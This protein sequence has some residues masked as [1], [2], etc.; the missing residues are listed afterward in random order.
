M[1]EHCHPWNFLGYC[2]LKLDFW[3][4]FLACKF[5]RQYSIQ[6]QFWIKFL[7]C[8]KKLWWLFLILSLDSSIPRKTGDHV[9]SYL[10][11]LLVNLVHFSCNVK[12]E[13]PITSSS[14]HYIELVPVH[15]SLVVTANFFLRRCSYR[16]LNSVNLTGGNFSSPYF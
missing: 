14:F 11:Y 12:K 3:R 10:Q 6:S 9:F 13:I 4:L 8:P 5:G 1:A 16:A 7:I 15:I 2:R